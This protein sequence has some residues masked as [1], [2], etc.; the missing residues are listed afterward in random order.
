MSMPLA[1]S[2]CVLIISLMQLV[3]GAQF[4]IFI[5]FLLFADAPAATVYGT[6]ILHSKIYV[7]HYN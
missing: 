6:I 5:F 3:N 1:L 4:L 2:V 7:H